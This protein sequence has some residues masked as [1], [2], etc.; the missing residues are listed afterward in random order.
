MCSGTQV[1][2]LTLCPLGQPNKAIGHESQIELWLP[3]VNRNRFACCTS[4]ID[5]V[6]TLLS[7]FINRLR[8]VLAVKGSLRRAENGAPLTAPGR[9]EQDLPNRRE[10]RSGNPMTPGSEHLA[11]S[12][13]NHA[14]ATP[15]RGTRTSGRGAGCRNFS[16][17]PA[18]EGTFSLDILFYRTLRGFASP[19]SIVSAL[20][21]SFREVEQPSQARPSVPLA[22]LGD[23]HDV[24]ENRVCRHPGFHQMRRRSRSALLSRLIPEFVDQRLYESCQDG[25]VLPVGWW[26]LSQS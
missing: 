23:D 6:C 15:P 24:L 1:S 21:P 17:L 3:H 20:P 19:K 25:V 26:A 5:R 4:E 11:A 2:L 12:R 22:E 18:R 16:R 8:T 13:Q 14:R 7:L 10:R 9:S